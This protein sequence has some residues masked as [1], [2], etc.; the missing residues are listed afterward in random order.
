MHLF[1]VTVIDHGGSIVTMMLPSWTGIY[2]LKRKRLFSEGQ[3]KYS[4]DLFTL[5]HDDMILDDDLTLADYFFP[6]IEVVLQI[7]YIYITLRH[8]T[9]DLQNTIRVNTCDLRKP[10][11]AITRHLG[12]EH[13]IDIRRAK[14]YLFNGESWLKS[15]RTFFPLPYPGQEIQWAWDWK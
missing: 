3:E 6:G 1:Q 4:P 12:D 7:S 2:T 11:S 15:T 10:P 13:N 9:S 5:S 14:F 8:G